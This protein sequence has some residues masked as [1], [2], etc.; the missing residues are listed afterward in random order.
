MVSMK[1]WVIETRA[2]RTGSRVCAAAAAMPA[3]PR[4]DS[5]EKIPR[6]TPKR[7]ACLTA[8][9]V[10]P[11]TAAVPE[12]APRRPSPAPLESVAQT[13]PEPTRAEHIGHDHDRYEDP[14]E[15]A[16]GLDAAQDHQAGRYSQNQPGHPNRQLERRS[17]RACA[18]EFDWTMLPMPKEAQT[19]NRAKTP[20]ERL[21]QPR[22]WM[23]LAR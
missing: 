6:A 2:C 17:V 21:A 23:P 12:K 4:P 20:T 9:P 10:N 1:V 8:A 3:E 18:T 16:D 14:G 15:P 5:F 13:A 11:P 7:I 19:A 22:H